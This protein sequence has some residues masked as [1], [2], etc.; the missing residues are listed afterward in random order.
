MENPLIAIVVEESNS[1][2]PNNP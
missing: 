1:S 2:I